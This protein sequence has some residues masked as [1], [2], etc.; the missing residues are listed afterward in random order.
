MSLVVVEFDNQQ[1]EANHIHSVLRDVNNDF[2][3]DVMR[4]HRL[5][6]HID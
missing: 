6:F 1:N 3:F 4:E 5:L 2:A